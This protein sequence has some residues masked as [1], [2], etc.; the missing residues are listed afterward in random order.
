MQKKPRQEANA[1]A[2]QAYTLVNDLREQLGFTWN[3]ISQAT[4]Y[5]QSS[6]SNWRGRGI[7]TTQITLVGDLIRLFAK[8][9]RGLQCTADDAARLVSLTYPEHVVAEHYQYL[10]GLFSHTELALA[11]HLH[12]PFVAYTLEQAGMLCLNVRPEIHL[13][14]GRLQA[15]RELQ[16]IGRERLLKHWRARL[17]KP[18]LR[19]L[20]IGGPGGIGKTQF[21]LHLADKLQQ[22]FTSVQ[23]IDL[24]NITQAEDV[25]GVLVR[26]ILPPDQPQT[27][28]T[29]TELGQLIDYVRQRQM[30]LV[31]DNLEQL[32]RPGEGLEQIQRLLHELLKATDWLKLIVTSRQTLNL[33]F[34]EHI[35]ELPPLAVSASEPENSGISPAVQLFIKRA[36]TWDA[37]FTPTLEQLQEISAICTRLDGIPL[38][39][40]LAAARLRQIGALT[41]WLTQL[42]LLGFASFDQA[43]GSLDRHQTLRATIEWSY[44]LLRADEQRI[45][46]QLAIFAD[47]WSLD[48]AQ[49]I[50]FPTLDQAYGLS[51]LGRLVDTSLIQVMPKATSHQRYTMYNV[52]REFALEYF[53]NDQTAVEIAQRHAHYYSQLAINLTTKIKSSDRSNALAELESL[54]ANIAIALEWLI[55][56]QLLE[57]ATLADSLT[58]FWG[59]RG[60]ARDG[61]RILLRF[62]PTALP[63]ALRPQFHYNLGWLY[64]SLRDYDAASKHYQICA[65]YWKHQPSSLDW[66]RVLY[67]QGRVARSQNHFTEAERLLTESLVALADQPEPWL[68][69]AILSVLGWVQTQMNT[70]EIAESTL[71]ESRRLSRSVG[72]PDLEAITLLNMGSLCARMA[73]YAS[74]QAYLIQAKAIFEQLG[75]LGQLAVCLNN[76]VAA[77]SDD[78][79]YSQAIDYLAELLPLLKTLDDHEGII[80]WYLNRGELA[81]KQDQFAQARADYVSALR[82]AERANFGWPYGAS[83]TALANIQAKIGHFTAAAQLIGAADQAYEV[84]GA[85]AALFDPWRS[86]TLGLIQQ[87]LNPE[88]ELHLHKQG[89][90]M[91][92]G[93]II[94]LSVSE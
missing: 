13:H 10:L 9:N 48:A 14:L 77:S 84:C 12:A 82:Q 18:D 57:A 1:R 68:Q 75:N 27:A 89:K 71:Q 94:Q 20:T 41:P 54:H 55:E 17:L 36:Q 87:Q 29:P 80:Y 26:Q 24:S 34:W 40:E 32:L 51:M 70:F 66:A 81:L 83:I 79:N 62:E 61:L 64:D 74:A 38:A 93:R 22:Q 45:F 60:Y 6:I 46:Q 11:L 28:G 43:G 59:V 76:L 23:S 78:H 69:T 47:G 4:T 63:Q 30:L 85:D 15:P 8:G 16:L 44:C 2:K 19:L 31:L 5:A 53:A 86:Q 72:D 92:I 65:S 91:P 42:N 37:T 58:Y 7:G 25:V 35:C 39:I 67:A 21:A 88:Q 52:I 49:A 3:D 33:P 73:E 50:C 90:R 56:H